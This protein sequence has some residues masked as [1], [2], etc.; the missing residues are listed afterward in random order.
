[1]F[2][3]A[4]FS[5]VSAYLIG[6]VSFS[7]LAGRLLRGI[8]LRQHGSGNLG[9]SNTFRV[10]GRGPGVMVLALDTLKGY[11][12]LALAG[13]LSFGN[14]TVEVLAGLAVILGH[15]FTLFHGFRG[16]KGVATGLG[17]FLYLVPQGVLAALV[18]FLAVFLS[19]GYV[20]LGSITAAL[21]LPLVLFIQRYIFGRSIPGLILAF[22][23]LTAFVIIFKHASNIRR[24]LAGTEN[25]FLWSRRT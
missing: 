11:L 20:S 10:L 18:V 17:V 19:S 22:A 21:T 24:L 13:Y 7:Y 15:I 8:D 12:A 16:G 1:V 4:V 14:L 9:A 2:W 5:L 25:R 3:A 6:S 23:T